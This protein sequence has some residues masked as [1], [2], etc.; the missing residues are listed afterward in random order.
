MCAWQTVVGV[1]PMSNA[2]S[3]PSHQIEEYWTAAVKVGEGDVVCAAC[4]VWFAAR[5]WRGRCLAPDC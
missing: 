5:F 2:P 1:V 3:G 4:V